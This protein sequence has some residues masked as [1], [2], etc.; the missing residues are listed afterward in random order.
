VAVGLRPQESGRRQLP[1]VL[2]VGV[3]ECPTVADLAE[4]ILLDPTQGYSSSKDGNEGED[5]VGQHSDRLR[6]LVR[7]Y[8]EGL[9][10]V[11][12]RASGG[13]YFV[14]NTY[15]DRLESLR[16]FVKHFGGG[17]CLP[18]RRIGRCTR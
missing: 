11:K 8:V 14:H 7:T 18:V 15:A 10:A 16:G 13:V 1:P 17:S 4:E 2:I 6:T 9:N 5:F 3:L 12:V